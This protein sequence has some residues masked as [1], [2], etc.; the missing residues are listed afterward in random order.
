MVGYL[1]GRRYVSLFMVLY[2]ERKRDPLE[3]KGLEIILGSGALLPQRGRE[4]Y[5]SC[6]TISQCVPGCPFGC[7]LSAQMPSSVVSPL[8][9]EFPS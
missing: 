3:R 8:P 4:G 6:H 5:L 2:L 7:F 9:Q 1:R